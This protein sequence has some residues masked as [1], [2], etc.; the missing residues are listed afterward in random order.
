[1]KKN[2][3]QFPTHLSLT[4]FTALFFFFASAL[5]A[6]IT[7]TR[8]ITKLPS[9]FIE[10]DWLNIKSRNENRD[11]FKKNTPVII[12]R[13]SAKPESY[14]KSRNNSRMQSEK[15]KSVTISR[16]PS[17]ITG[18]Y[19]GY[20]KSRLGYS[21]FLGNGAYN[22]GDSVLKNSISGKIITIEPDFVVIRSSEDN[23]DFYALK[24]HLNAIEIALIKARLHLKSR[25]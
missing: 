19:H 1:M 5:S 6:Q 10:P 11:S 7:H 20:L 22:M 25:K 21:V 18:L 12:P 2:P 17:F 14:S 4:F 3:D 15:N 9:P 13:D 16:E 24:T 8:L 23:V